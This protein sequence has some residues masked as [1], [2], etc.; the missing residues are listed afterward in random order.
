MH[1]C[2]NNQIQRA[3][4]KCPPVWAE[5]PSFCLLKL[6][7]KFTIPRIANKETTFHKVASHLDTRYAAEV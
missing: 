6:I 5:K 2:N 7:P 1:E 4:V 3:S